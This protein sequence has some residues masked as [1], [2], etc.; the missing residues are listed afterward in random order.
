M[1]EMGIARIQF[2][3]KKVEANRIRFRDEHG[4]DGSQILSFFPDR[5]RIV[6]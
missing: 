3:V 6:S 2:R 4:P 1:A 5:N